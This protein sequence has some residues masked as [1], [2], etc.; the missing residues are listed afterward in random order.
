MARAAA[1][2]S[3]LIA[4]NPVAVT[5]ADAERIYADVLNIAG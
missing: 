2:N 4:P 5:A 3:R 1:N